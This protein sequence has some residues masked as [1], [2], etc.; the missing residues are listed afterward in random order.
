MSDLAASAS[1]PAR[2]VCFAHGKES[3]PW[4]TKITHLATTARRRGFEVISPDYS[5]TADP[6]GRV[7]QLL[8]LA[9]R[10]RCL[11]L[12]GSSM[13]GYVSAMACEALAPTALLLMAPALYFPGF[14]EEPSG[15]PAICSVVH[16]WADDIVP[17]DRAIRFARTHG[18]ELHML[19]SAHTLTD[20]LPA[21]ERIFD[22]L[23]SRAIEAAEGPRTPDRKQL[24]AAY[25]R[26]E[27]WV[28]L[29]QGAIRLGAGH[30]DFAADGALAEAGGMVSG[31]A[32][33]TPFNPRGQTIDGNRNSANLEK[34]RS[35]LLKA[36]QTFFAACNRD[37]GGHWPD[38]DGFLIIDPEPQLPE[39]LGR[40]FGQ[41]AIL[42]GEP[43]QPSRLVW[44]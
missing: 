13:G 2:L 42:R 20:Q 29:P 37:P 1:P 21:L 24:E 8:D 43:G 18:A 5:H 28:D 12:V 7:Q 9:P 33:V 34:L 22:T 3:G 41:H 19:A 11:V 40:L 30:A 26:A 14:D 6:R 27:Y 31:W 38:E 44:L 39:R 23:L 10:A 16:G 35:E 4:G 36:G 32:L 25:A 17:P 15:I